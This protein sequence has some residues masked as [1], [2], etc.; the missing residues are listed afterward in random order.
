MF[1]VTDRCNARC[2][3]CYIWAKTPKR[4]LPV[5]IIEQV[6][7]DKA[8]SPKTRIGM[9]GGEFLLHPQHEEILDLLAREHPAIDLL[10]NC[11]LPDKLVYLVNT[12]LSPLKS[13]K[14]P[15]RL[16]ISL[17][18]VRAVHDHLRGIT[19]LYD[20]V[21]KVID[22]LCGHFP[23]SVMFTLTPFN[24][25]QDL[26]HVM[27]LCL[28]YG[29]DLRIGIYNNMQYFDTKVSSLTP[30]S[31][32]DYAISDIPDEVKLFD[33][34]YDFMVLYHHFRNGNLSLTC[35]S[36]KDCVVV[37]PNGDIPLCQNKK[38]ILG[39]LYSESLY[40]IIN[41]K[42][43][44]QLHRDYRNCNGCWI[45]FHRKYDIILYRNIERI[46]GKRI[47]EIALGKY[48]WCDDPH[49]SYRDIMNR[50]P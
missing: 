32:L 14:N 39:N 20:N 30:G 45:N 36:I 33:E 11:M 35:N 2:K 9:E 7:S 34:N 44:R 22:T 13:S 50:K 4:S 19:G 49:K 41:K 18:G 40:Q 48:K 10:S 29:L 24:S 21:R 3:H 38:I 1:Y 25:F 27:E 12:F 16:F 23:I 17:D 6:L 42:S 47:V 37:Y 43:S 5:E 46:F 31:S 8:V 26:R 15:P 28:M